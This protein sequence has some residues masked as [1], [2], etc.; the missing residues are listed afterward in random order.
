M[1]VQ[2]KQIYT[3]YG[4]KSLFL[5]LSVRLRANSHKK[6][7]VLANRAAWFTKWLFC[8][9]YLQDS[10]ANDPYLSL[11]SGDA[12]SR[13]LQGNHQDDHWCRSQKGRGDIREGYT[14]QGLTITFPEGLFVV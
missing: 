9:G 13:G 12:G 8:F 5:S 2:L 3:Y 6:Y 4:Q 11:A 10:G 7:K 14:T 1:F